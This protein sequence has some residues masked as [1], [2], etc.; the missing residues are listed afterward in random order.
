MIGER[1]WPTVVSDPASLRSGFLY[2]KKRTGYLEYRDDPEGKVTLLGRTCDARST[3]ET[4]ST[5]SKDARVALYG[6]QYC[7]AGGFCAE[8]LASSLSGEKAQYLP[9]YTS[10]NHPLSL[11]TPHSAD[12]LRLIRAFYSTSRTAHVLPAR[13]RAALTCA[14]DS[15]EGAELEK[16]LVEHTLDHVTG[17]SVAM[18]RSCPEDSLR[19]D[20]VELVRLS[21]DTHTVQQFTKLLQIA[22]C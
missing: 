13:L 2:V 12:Q 4:I 19:S 14:L 10:L 16:G 20:V 11:L 21:N 9:L 18:R 1:Y 22:G 7:S 17:K 8:Q 6:E 15:G 5:F 3:Q